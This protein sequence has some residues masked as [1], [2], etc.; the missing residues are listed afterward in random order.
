MPMFFLAM[1][2]EVHGY[3]A[4]AAHRFSPIFCSR[5]PSKVYASL[6]RNVRPAISTGIIVLTLLLTDKALAAPAETCA[7][8]PEIEASLG[9][10]W[11]QKLNE[12][13]IGKAVTKE[14]LFG[15]AGTKA[16]VK[17]SGGHAYVGRA[18]DGSVA[19]EVR[20]PAGEVPGWE[21]QSKHLEGRNI[22][23]AGFAADIWLPGGFRFPNK[24]TGSSP[25]TGAQPGQGRWPFGMWIGGTGYAMAGGVP[26]SQQNG[27]SVRLNRS[28]GQDGQL[29][30]MG[31]YVY[32]LNRITPQC[33][34][35]GVCSGN[36]KAGTTGACYGYYNP[37]KVTAL[38]RDRWV[39]LEM[40]V[41]MND[42]GK[43]NGE[44]S[45]WRDGE[46]MQRTSG[47]D[48]GRDRNWFIKGFYSWEMWHC[49][50]SPQAEKYW[51]RNLRLYANDVP[52]PAN[53]SQ[54]TLPPEVT[55]TPA[56]ELHS[57]RI[58]AG[59]SA[60]YT[61]ADGKV[62]IAD[63]HFK[64]G[65]TVDR[66]NI[67]VS[68]TSMSHLFR[69]ERYGLTGYSIPVPN[70]KY[71]TVKLYF[72]ETNKYVAA[73]GKRVFDVN[74][75]G[76]KFTSLD[77]YKEAGGLNKALVKTADVTV[78]DGKVDINFTA[79]VQGTMINAIEILQKE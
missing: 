67:S 65:K 72:A 43:Q 33:T 25:K 12:N 71:Y 50:P 36:C 8:A 13:D 49:Q 4:N 55:P 31:M 48:F 73:V 56:S 28:G 61:A 58:E 62:W 54:P 41:K 3:I 79:K 42:P 70:N 46:L 47:F 30:G 68:G 1:A 75:E 52:K 6:T 37:N 26:L 24:C 11:Q 7:A 9:C 59:G 38:P 23:H 29:A 32:N 60:S 57:L 15:S 45:F 19:I 53:P 35:T 27:A 21:I 14:I 63:D 2:T 20:H 69:T 74:V 64:D 40:T 66:G 77:V 34:A 17:G 10:T 51:F 18:P 5:T 44:V 22:T 76:V 39:R 16:E 78:T